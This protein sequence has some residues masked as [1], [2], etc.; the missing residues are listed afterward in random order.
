MR[1]IKLNMGLNM[2]SMGFDVNQQINMHLR[3]LSQRMQFLYSGH[4]FVVAQSGYKIKLQ[5]YI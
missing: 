1:N 3:G 5:S 2:A 4:T